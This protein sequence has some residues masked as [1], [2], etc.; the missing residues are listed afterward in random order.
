MGLTSA[1][2]RLHALL[3][4]VLAGLIAMVWFG[5]HQA[6][7]QRPALTAIDGATL[8]ALSVERRSEPPISLQ[9]HDGEWE[10]TS[11]DRLEASSPQVSDLLAIFAAPVVASYPRAS[12]DTAELQL[13]QPL[14]E[15]ATA[16][17]HIRFGARGRPEGYRYVAIDEDVHLISDRHYDT[18]AAPLADFVGTKPLPLGDLARI[19]WADDLVLVASDDGARWLLVGATEVTDGGGLAAAWLSLRARSVHPLDPATAPGATMLVWLRERSRPIQF[20]LITTPDQP[21]VLLRRDLAL[22]YVLD[23]N[24]TGPLRPAGTE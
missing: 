3:G 23:A 7:E 16:G 15:I 10:L 22:L 18:V 24:A 2:R 12:V 4:A 21:P 1:R 17:V 19:E 9:Q 8:A 6:P 13:D 5:R 20:E 14:A 11:P